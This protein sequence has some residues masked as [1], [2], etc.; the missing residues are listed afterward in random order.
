MK[1]DSTDTMK[2]FSS[3]AT[4]E[5]P[6]IETMSLTGSVSYAPS[7]SYAGSSCGASEAE[8]L[9]VDAWLEAIKPGYGERFHMAFERLGVEDAADV[10]NIDQRFYGDLHAALLECGAKPMH[11][12]NIRLALMDMG[13]SLDPITP[14]SMETGGGGSG[15]F[16]KDDGKRQ[17]QQRAELELGEDAPRP[18]EHR[19]APE[20]R[21]AAMRPARDAG[22][23]A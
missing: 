4:Y 8:T 2:S 22:H 6:E 9:H 14:S 16:Q 21:R 19:Q 23:H 12:K 18:R 5:M 15:S 3:A 13:C 17:Q 20:P 11:I 10:A 7:I 1:E